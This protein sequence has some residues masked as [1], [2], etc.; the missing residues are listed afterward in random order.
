VCSEIEESDKK[1]LYITN[2]RSTRVQQKIG[3][4]VDT[5]LASLLLAE[6][7]GQMGDAQGEK[8]I[9]AA[10]HKVMDKIERNQQSDGTWDKNGW[11]PVL[12]QSLAGKA[13]N[14]GAQ[15][16]LKVNEQVRA[17]AETYARKQFAEAGK[18]ASGPAVMMGRSGGFAGGGRGGAG[19]F[20][21]EGAAG[22]PL[23]SF[24]GN[25]SV[26]QDSANTNGLMEKEARDKLKSARTNQEKKAALSTLR[27]FEDAKRDLQRAQ[28]A[29]IEKMEDKEFISGFGSNGGEEFL[30]YMNIGE[31]LVAKGGPEWRKWDKSMTQNLNRIQ[32]NDGTWSGHHCIT[33]RTFCTSAALL[34]LTVDRAPVP[35]ATRISRR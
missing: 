15:N 9:A 20:A 18:A 5:F 26:M 34:V 8:R 14:R 22:V 10:F 13:L 32:N 11:A 31:S 4:Y 2:N 19:G 27:R 35:L 33:G 29:V 3:P 30:S 23:Y 12:G 16:G 24:G 1:S 17:R 28:S 21:G 25:L 7:K 6:V